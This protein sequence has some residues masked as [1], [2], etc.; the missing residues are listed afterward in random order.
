MNG[1]AECKPRE[2]DS[3]NIKK[4][5]KLK[6]KNFF[7]VTRPHF[8]L[9]Y[10]VDKKSSVVMMQMRANHLST[11]SSHPT[12]FVFTTFQTYLNLFN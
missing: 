7:L 1:W 10:S 8:Y 3:E 2:R 12:I 9:S 11:K 5:S 4:L 6:K